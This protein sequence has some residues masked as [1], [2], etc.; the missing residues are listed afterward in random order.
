MLYSL[1]STRIYVWTDTHL[2]DYTWFTNN[3]SDL[4]KN[5]SISIN[6]QNYK[7]YLNKLMQDINLNKVLWRENYYY[8]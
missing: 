4:Q 1:C 8:N 7:S 5:L 6:H 2:K 3:I